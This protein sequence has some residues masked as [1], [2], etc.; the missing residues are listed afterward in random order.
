MDAIR[1]DLRYIDAGRLR[2]T[3]DLLLG[4]TVM[5]PA[6]NIIGTLTGALIDP[7]RRHVSFLIVESRNWFATHRYVVPL[8]TARFDPDRKALLVDVEADGLRELHGD[9]FQRFSDADLI[10]AMFSPL[11]A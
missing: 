9:R 10:T 6:G 5:S 11:A 4:A 2:T 7:S 8:G 3:G 1:N